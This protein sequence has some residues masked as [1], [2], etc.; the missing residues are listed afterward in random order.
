[1]PRSASLPKRSDNGKLRPEFCSSVLLPDPGGPI[2]TY[3]GKVYRL[4]PPRRVLR[5]VSIASW[6][7]PCNCVRSAVLRSSPA[8][9]AP[10]PARSP[11][12][13]LVLLRTRNCCTCRHTTHT[14][15][16]STISTSRVIGLAS[17]CESPRPRYG[18]PSQINTDSNTIPTRVMNQPVL[19]NVISLLTRSTLGDVDDFDAAIARAI[20]R[21]IG[22]QS[23]RLGR[24]GNAGFQ[25]YGV[26]DAL[27]EDLQHR[28][29]ACCRQR[30][31]V[32]ELQRVDRL[33]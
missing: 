5:R 12:I 23:D 1:M 13:C 26:V 17:G 29:G 11:D 19:N 18:P 8:S 22:R 16:I 20:G 21:K 7:R 4:L 14:T 9:C 3:H 24:A 2:T 27:A 6:K 15:T 33:V 30:E 32:L 25:P 10:C 28:T 31:V